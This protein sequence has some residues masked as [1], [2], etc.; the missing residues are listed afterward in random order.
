V[1]LMRKPPGVRETH[2]DADRA[3]DAGECSASV[4]QGQRFLWEGNGSQQS[5]S[6]TGSLDANLSLFR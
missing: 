5:L 6:L 4:K 1:M 2:S 3:N